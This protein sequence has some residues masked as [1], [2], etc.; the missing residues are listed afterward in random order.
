MKTCIYYGHYCG[1]C[2][3]RGRWVVLLVKV[4]R[5]DPFWLIIV[6]VVYY[7]KYATRLFRSGDYFPVP[8][9]TS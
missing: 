8:S 3:G 1:A 4:L 9:F 6:S 5:H 2:D 7:Y